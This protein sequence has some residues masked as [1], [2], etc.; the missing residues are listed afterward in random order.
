VVTFWLISI[1]VG[2]LTLVTKG[3]CCIWL[4]NKEWEMFLET[5]KSIKLLIGFGAILPNSFT[6][7]EFFSSLKSHDFCNIFQYPLPLVVWGLMISRVRESIYMLTWF[8]HW[9]LFQRC[10]WEEFAMMEKETHVAIIILQMQFL[11]S[12]HKKNLVFFP[13]PKFINF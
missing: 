2:H 6:N 12:F 7:Q 9:G 3:G 13:L 4:Q 5:L 1:S 11:T 8:I 10:G